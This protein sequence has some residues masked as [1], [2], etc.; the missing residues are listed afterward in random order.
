MWKRLGEQD[1][2]N[3]EWEEVFRDPKRQE[4]TMELDSEVDIQGMLQNKFEQVNDP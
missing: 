4:H 1:S 3:H 2:S